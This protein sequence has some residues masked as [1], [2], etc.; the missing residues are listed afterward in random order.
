VFGESTIVKTSNAGD[1]GE[2]AVLKLHNFVQ[3]AIQ[4]PLA[5]QVG[6]GHAAP[7]TTANS[8]CRA[9]STN[10]STVT[11]VIFAFSPRLQKRAEIDHKMRINRDPVHADATEIF[12]EITLT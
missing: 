2:A 7:P 3:T 9:S 11:C 8:A 10:H 4:K 12:R 6:D 1:V 5:S